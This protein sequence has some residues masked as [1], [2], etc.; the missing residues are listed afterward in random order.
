[1]I[2]TLANQLPRINLANGGAMQRP[3]PASEIWTTER[4]LADLKSVDLKS[5]CT[6]LSFVQTF[7]RNAIRIAA[8]P[9]LVMPLSIG[10][11]RNLSETSRTWQMDITE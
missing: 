9:R 4:F 1:M 2:T 8:K 10:D 7:L 6:H 11:L 3:G 5:Q